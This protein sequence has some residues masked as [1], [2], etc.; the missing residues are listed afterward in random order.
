VDPE[1]LTFN[2]NNAANVPITS[3][4]IRPNDTQVIR[5]VAGVGAGTF[6]VRIV[7]RV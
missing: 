3:V 1:T 5:V 6:R 7:Y 4:L 2:A